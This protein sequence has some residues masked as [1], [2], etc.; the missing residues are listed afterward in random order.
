MWIG[1][2]EVEVDGGVGLATAI[3]GCVLGAVVDLFAVEPERV[4]FVIAAAIAAAALEGELVMAGRGRSEDTGPA[5]AVVRL[6]ELR[7]GSGGIPV[8][9][10]FLVDARSGGLAGEVWIAEVLALEAVFSRACRGV[11]GSARQD[12]GQVVDISGPL[13]IRDSGLAAEGGLDAV[14]RKRGVGGDG[15]VVAFN[16][17]ER[18]GVGTDDRDLFEAWLKRENAVILEQDDGLLGRFQGEGE[19]LRRVNDRKGDLCVL[20]FRRRIEHAE[21]EACGEETLDGS[22]DFGLGNE[23]LVDGIDEGFIRLAAVRVCAGFH[24]G[25][26]G[27]RHV[28]RVV[29]ASIGKE[30]ADGA[31]VRRDEAMEAP[32][33]VKVVLQELRVGAG[34]NVID[35]VVGAHDGVG[36][37][38]LDGGAEGRE[39]GV[40]K[41]VE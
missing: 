40:F 21:L 8:E 38:I 1:I 36:V 26:A 33:L 39:I 41:V 7:N 6:A 28:G 29:M 15:V 17:G 18:S 13:R 24:R 34:G 32:V 23:V 16:R 5:D 4:G 37:R 2:G 27:V 22:I 19:V 35:S 12:D 30:V 11:E 10:D 9:V 14:D 31:A 3:L 25:R 20:H